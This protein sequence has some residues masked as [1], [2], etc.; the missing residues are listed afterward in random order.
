MIEE[1]T[2]INATVDAEAKK[3]EIGEYTDEAIS[4]SSDAYQYIVKR[5]DLKEAVYNDDHYLSLFDGYEDTVM[6][7]KY[8][9]HIKTY[10][11]NISVDEAVS[12]RYTFTDTFLSEYADVNFQYYYY[13]LNG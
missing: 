4:V 7:D 10:F 11:E 8:E 1:G 13:G 5:I 6:Y 2:F 9:N 12:A 3:L